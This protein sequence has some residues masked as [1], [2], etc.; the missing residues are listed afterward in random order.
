[1]AKE[2]TQ[3]QMNQIKDAVIASCVS[4][5]IKPNSPQYNSCV[6]LGY[7]DAVNHATQGKLGLWFDK[8]G[9]FVQSQGGVTGL[10]QSVSSIANQYRG[11]TANLTQPDG[12]TQFPPGYDADA[13]GSKGDSDNMGI[14]LV[15]VILLIVLIIATVIY[16]NKNKSVTA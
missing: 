2:L 1:M 7:N 8:V 15:L 3:E 14:W 13:S 6:Q 5:G 12:T 16:F 11:N 9:S 10:L 4:K